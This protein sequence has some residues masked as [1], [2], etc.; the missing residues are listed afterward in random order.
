[1]QRN[2]ILA[3][4]AVFS[5]NVI[6]GV[7]Y[8]VAKGIMPDFMTPRAI[9]LVRVV[10]SALVFWL[11]SFLFP[12]EKLERRDFF[13]L[14][15]ISFFGVGINQ[16]LFF[17]GLNLTTPINAAIIMV[18]V[19]I[20]VLVL[21]WAIYRKNISF[22]MMFGIV[23]GMSG[24]VYLVLQSG[25]IS[26][27]SSNFVGN[28]LILINAASYSLYLVLVKPLMKKYSPIT[29]MKWVFLLSIIYVAPVSTGLF[30][31]T[32]FSVFTINT[33]LS[34]GFIVLFTTI[35]AYFF[36]NFSLKTISPAANSA[37]IYL[38]PVFASFVAL[39]LGI[40]KITA[41]EIIA[42]ILIFI[43]VYLVSFSKT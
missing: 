1:M 7:N 18:S 19:P 21:T 41:Y 43:G 8:V 28:L 25:H 37:F 23:T 15:Y 20:I 39:L 29:I 16:I 30:I 3:Y 6:Y 22:K 11:V 24:A 35:L 40:D 13:K 26:L 27:Q 5:A 10:V 42:A 17:E 2:Q 38:Q 32:D 34:L 36:N 12:G 4:L 31:K 9:I 33:W 14:L